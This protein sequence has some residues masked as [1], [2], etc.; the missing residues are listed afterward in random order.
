MEQTIGSPSEKTAYIRNAGFN[1][2]PNRNIK[3]IFLVSSILQMN[4]SG[5]LNEN[6]KDKRGERGLID[7]KLSLNPISI[8]I[9]YVPVNLSYSTAY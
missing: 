3:A 1:M 6:I 4:C 2:N 5:K 9:L 8:C 7:D